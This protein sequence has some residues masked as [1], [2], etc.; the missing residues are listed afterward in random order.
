MQLTSSC[1]RCQSFISEERRSAALV[2]CDSCGH[3]L[4]NSQ[5]KMETHS[6]K[7]NLQILVG[8]ALMMIVTLAH[9]GSWGSYALEIRWLQLRD[10]TGTASSE[11]YEHMAVICKELKK[12]DCA[13][14]AYFRQSRLMPN[15]RIKLAEFQ[16]SR[17][18][19]NEATKTLRDY[20]SD[21]KDPSAYF[22]YARALGEA[23]K[24]DEA[25]HCYETL[26]DGSGKKLSQEIVDSY[27]KHLARAKRYEQARDVIVKVRRRF[28]KPRNF[29]ES[30]MRILAELSHPATVK[31]GLASVTSIPSAEKR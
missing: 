8:L 10:L 14:Y 26:L 1:P 16:M 22:T 28:S 5:F 9:L 18:K 20:V 15:N 2:V 11:N 21:K 4:S 25:A 7:R 13:E 12:M 29:M 6:E 27:V 31:R 3:V 24:I 23:G 19:F 30:E 17:H